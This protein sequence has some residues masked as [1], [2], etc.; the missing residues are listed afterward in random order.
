MNPAPIA[1]PPIGL[2]LGSRFL[3]AAQANRRGEIIATASVRRKDPGEPYGPDDFERLCGALYRRGFRGREVVVTAPKPI[4]QRASID[5]PPRD[6]G[7]PLAEIARSELSRQTHQD[8]ASFEFA[9]WDAPQPPR[10][11][12]STRAITVSCDHAKANALL[13]TIEHSG[14]V[15]LAM[16]CPSAA[17]AAAT[18]PPDPGALAGA[19]D[20]GWSE[21]TF[22]VRTTD[23]IV[24]ERQ[25][26]GCE[27]SSI[28]RGVSGKHRV[29][30]ARLMRGIER[31]GQEGAS[32][33]AAATELSEQIRLH[34]RDEMRSSIEY[35]RNCEGTHEPVF[36]A[37]LGG[38][39][40]TPGIA[41]AISQATEIA[42]CVVPCPGGPELAAAH[43]LAA[44]RSC[45]TIG[46][47]A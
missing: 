32:P 1:S 15:P 23:E 2:D 19:L 6:S 39:A 45:Y 35:L 17:T 25:L 38:G 13:D 33:L 47:A 24:F 46:E 36:I 34:V 29:D 8:P 4:V 20:L 12:T 31:D 11:G 3:H 43:A 26:S 27:V 40:R 37:V 44:P 28:I 5:L 16:L 22:V 21:S 9:W 14:L 7:A 10:H 30:P 42:A 41:E 18:P